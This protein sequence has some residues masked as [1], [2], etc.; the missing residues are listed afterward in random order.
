VCLIIIIQSSWSLR[1]AFSWMT[2]P[3]HYGMFR[4]KYEMMF[5]LS[6]WD[7][8]NEIIKKETTRR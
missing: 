3:Y 5:F 2:F 8:I 6:F 7:K 1:K 4:K